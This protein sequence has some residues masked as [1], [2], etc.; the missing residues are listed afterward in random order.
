MLRLVGHLCSGGLRGICDTDA[1]RTQAMNESLPFLEIE[2]RVK[3]Y[4]QKLKSPNLRK[5]LSEMLKRKSGLGGEKAGGDGVVPP[6]RRR[7]YSERTMSDLSEERDMDA[8]TNQEEVVIVNHSLPDH[9]ETGKLENEHRLI[10]GETM[11]QVKFENAKKSRFYFADDLKLKSQ[12]EE[13]R[14]AGEAFE[15]AKKMKDAIEVAKDE[16]TVESELSLWRGWFLALYE[17]ESR[18]H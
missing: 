7:R 4:E 8:I 11:Y 6:V 13:D 18:G 2:D 17:C 9:D 12:I 5:S 10:G 1:A 15:E 16:V 14:R 3:L